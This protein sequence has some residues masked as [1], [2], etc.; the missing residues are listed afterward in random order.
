M[1]KL[2][3]SMCLLIGI[4]GCPVDSNSERVDWDNSGNPPVVQPIVPKPEQKSDYSATVQ[5]LLNLHNKEREMK[6]RAAMA[7]DPYLVEYAQKYAEEM[8]R[9]GRLVHS[10]I[11]VLMGKY[12][13]A[14]ENIAWNQENE[15]EVVR[16]WMN[17]SGHRANI[18][19]RNF[20]KVGFGVAKAK[21]GSLY[22]CTVFGG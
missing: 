15:E 5:T 1:K 2:F 9:K 13:T 20:I 3:V 22:W 8:A 7:I 10:N 6:G 21:D 19:N 17:S 11:S 16:D 18:M 4:T 14:G 12:S